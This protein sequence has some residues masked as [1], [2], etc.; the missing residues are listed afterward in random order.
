MQD[1]DEEQVKW[2]KL[3]LANRFVNRLLRDKMDGEMLKFMA[4]ETAFKNIKI[5]TGV[6]DVNTFVDKFLNKE[7]AYGDLL[8]KIA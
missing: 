1:K 5:C 7:S 4:V 8:G 2:E 3:Y 6:S